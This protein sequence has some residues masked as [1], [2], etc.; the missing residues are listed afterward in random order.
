M[1]QLLPHTQ[2]QVIE[3]CGH[4]P[5]EECPQAVANIIQE[6]MNAL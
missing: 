1:V 2:M 3:K 5:H 6:F 4:V